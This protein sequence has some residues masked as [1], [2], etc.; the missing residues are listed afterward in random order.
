MKYNNVEIN[1]DEFLQQ[2]AKD[3]ISYL[4][5][6]GWTNKTNEAWKKSLAEIINGEIESSSVASEGQYAGQRVIHTN[7]NFNIESLSKKQKRIYSDVAWFLDQEMEKFA[8]NKQE[9]QE[10]QKINLPKFTNDQFSI[11]F[12]KIIANDRYGGQKFTEDQWNS[13]DERD[14]TGKRDTS[15]RSQLLANYLRQYSDQITGKY[16]Y[17]DSPFKSEQD[18]KERIN[19][20]IKSLEDGVWDQN[21]IDNLNRI[22]INPEIYLSNGLKDIKG[23]IEGNPITYEEYNSLVEQQAKAEEENKK[24]EQEKLEES[25]EALRFTNL[26]EY[27]SPTFA[28]DL[29]FIENA[30][31]RTIAEKYPDEE[32]LINDLNT[33]AKKEGNLDYKDQAIVQSAFRIF[34]KNNMLEDLDDN[35]RDLLSKV[36]NNVDG[37]KKIKGVTGIYYDPTTKNFFRGSHGEFKNDILSQ[38]RK[39]TTPTTSPSDKLVDKTWSASD[40]VEAGALVGDIASLVYPGAIGGAAFGTTAALARTYAS[41]DKGTFNF[42]D[43]LL[44]IGTGLVGG[45]PVLGD[46]LMV[47]KIGRGVKGFLQS[48]G[49]LEAMFNSPEFAS[50]AKKLS[51]GDYSD[52]TVDEWKGMLTFFR[53][54]TGAGRV[55]K[56]NRAITETAKRSGLEVNNSFR[57]RVFGYGPKINTTNSHNFKAKV[58]EKEINVELKN[59][60]YDNLIKNLKKVRPGKKSQEKS[61]E[62]IKKAIEPKIK[63]IKP[64]VKTEDITITYSPTW[65]RFLPFTGTKNVASNLGVTDSEIAGNTIEEFKNSLQN[66]SAWDKFINGSNKTLMRY[67]RSLIKDK[68]GLINPVTTAESPNAR[69]P[70]SQGEIVYGNSIPEIYRP[71]INY[72]RETA[73]RYRDIIIN[74][75]FSN[76]PL[77]LGNDKLGKDALSVVQLPN[78][79]YSLLHKGNVVENS[80]NQ[81]HIQQAV[82]NVIQQNIKNITV[83][84]MGKILRDYKSKGWLKYGGKIKN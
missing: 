16:D 60:E 57:G 23:T 62:I 52:I 77:V 79:S 29:S 69:Q 44:D 72:N 82:A 80:Y 33:I 50:V 11:D 71:G 83:E 75:N 84:E 35:D 46:A 25:K 45:I 13:I 12:N 43:R 22:G 51:K 21:D 49:V 24:K 28:K 26:E 3:S 7:K 27:K 40:I 56:T 30:A 78:G 20:A 74:K 31:F 61:Q 1:Q 41:I 18:L 65:R 14:S 48:A 70:L 76:T 63:E 42:W 15:K 8:N 5:E 34:S 54:I 10:E 37:L 53:G 17:T 47:G 66:R 67:R 4:Q 36:S 9:K 59:E 19:T 32:S 2:V 68:S 39:P 81:K 64:D 73:Q 55:Y 6:Q 58:G 38:Y